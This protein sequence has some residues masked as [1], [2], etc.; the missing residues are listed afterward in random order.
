MKRIS[1][2]V[3]L[4][5]L[6]LTVAACGSA[7]KVVVKKSSP[8]RFG[9]NFG[10]GYTINRGMAGVTIAVARTATI[11][12]VMP[13]TVIR[14]KGERVTVTKQMRG[15]DRS[16]SRD[17]GVDEAGSSSGSGATRE[18]HI[19]LRHFPNRTVTVDCG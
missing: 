19:E 5:A 16:Y 1:V 9:I 8:P 18:T 11:P 15:L 7:K 2:L 17:Y 14:C 3:V 10:K 12:Q 6:C 4:C 13:G